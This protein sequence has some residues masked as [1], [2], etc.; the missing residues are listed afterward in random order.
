MKKLVY[1]TSA[2]AAFVMVQACEATTV[3]GGNISVTPAVRPDAPLPPVDRTTSTP[4]TVAKTP[5]STTPS[6]STTSS[7]ST[8]STASTTPAASSNNH[9]PL[10]ASNNHAPVPVNPLLSSTAPVLT[11]LTGTHSTG[12]SSTGSSGYS[13]VPLNTSYRP[14][15]PLPRKPTSG[16]GTTGSGGTSGHPASVADGGA[17][18]SLFGMALL[19][20]VVMKRKLKR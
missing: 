15:A 12:V 10:P 4:F 20:T 13:P 7:A 8:T 9:A 14:T 16:G 1:I 17:T 18:M 19:G 5:S 6:S 11:S 3:S 2:L